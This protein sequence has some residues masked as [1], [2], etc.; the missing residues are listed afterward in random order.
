MPDSLGVLGPMVLDDISDGG[1][2]LHIMIHSLPMRCSRWTIPE[3]EALHK[4]N[5]GCP[6]DEPLMSAF[7]IMAFV[8]ALF[9]MN[10]KAGVIMGSLGLILV[11]FLAHQGDDSTQSR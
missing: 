10:D 4:K 1:V 2:G 8:I 7:Y 5:Q 3:S 9:R 11:Y 6:G